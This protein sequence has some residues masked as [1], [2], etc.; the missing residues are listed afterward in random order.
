MWIYTLDKVRSKLLRDALSIYYP[1]NKLFTRDSLKGV[2][3]RYTTQ[4]VLDFEKFQNNDY[5]NNLFIQSRNYFAIPIPDQILELGCGAGNLTIPLLK[6]TSATIFATDISRQQLS[7][8]G[9]LLDSGKFS[10]RVH[11]IQL[12]SSQDFFENSSFDLIVGSAIA[13][14]LIDPL[15][16]IDL[17]LRWLRV[18]GSLLFF[19]PILSGSLIVRK[20]ILE[21]LNLVS[22]DLPREVVKFLGGIAVD[23]AA[24]SDDLTELS[25]SQRSK[26]DDK[27]FVDI[28]LIKQKFTNVVVAVM[29]IL[30]HTSNRVLSQHIENILKYY[31]LWEKFELLPESFWNILKRYD[32]L[33]STSD[34]SP[35]IEGAIY[36]KRV[37]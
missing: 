10:H 17:S 23:I 21:V 27:S 24:R 9:G 19:E 18:N 11:L 15:V 26:L 8:L 33:F 20:A 12:D 37:S 30:D 16:L 28:D 6:N 13:H 36:I 14:H 2:S 4:A 35:V 1:I 29:P 7:I 3:A 22:T 25:Y 34:S 31:L 5:L 32:P